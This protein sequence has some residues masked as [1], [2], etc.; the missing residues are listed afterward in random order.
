[1]RIGVCVAPRRQEPGV[2]NNDPINPKLIQQM[3]A[4]RDR[5]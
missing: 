1:M 3:E 4:T 5:P 2:A